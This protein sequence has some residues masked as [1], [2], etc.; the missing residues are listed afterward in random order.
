MRKPAS[1]DVLAQLS[2]LHVLQIALARLAH[3]GFMSLADKD[4]FTP[5]G[6]RNAVV[7]ACMSGHQDVFPLWRVKN[8]LRR[9]VVMQLKSP[10]EIEQSLSDC[11]S[12]KWTSAIAIGHLVASLKGYTV[13]P[14]EVLRVV[15]HLPPKLDKFCHSMFPR[16]CPE[17]Y[18]HCILTR[19]SVRES[20][21]YNTFDL[22]V[23][24]SSDIFLAIPGVSNVR[25]LMSMPHKV[26]IQRRHKKSM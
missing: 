6:K 21:T 25:H 19:I 20:T 14:A 10:P 11:R 4:R 1:H 3:F 24:V 26:N 16:Q 15:E 13:N 7:I 12:R 9:C 8:V 2:L 18:R 23:Y 17:L 22:L 5:L